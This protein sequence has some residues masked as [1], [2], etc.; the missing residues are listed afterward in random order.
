MRAALRERPYLG[1]LASRPLLLTLMATLHSSWG[2]LPEDRAELYEET[3]KLLLGRWQR[4]REVRRPDGELEVEPGIA[5]TLGVG[6]ERIRA[7]LEALAFAVHERQRSSPER[8]AAPADIA[9]GDLLVAFKPL[10]GSLA[11]IPCWP[12]C[13]TGP[14]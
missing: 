6:E 2:Q 11:P 1:D 10:L 8:D 7:A 5:Q 9:E 3:V 4:A 13:A 14:T 12:T